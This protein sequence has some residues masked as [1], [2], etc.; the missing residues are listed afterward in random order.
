MPWERERVEEDP[1]RL[2]LVP[3]VCQVLR[4]HPGMS[5]NSA[6]VKAAA[7][8]ELCEQAMLRAIDRAHREPD[9]RD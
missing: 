1:Q 8:E 3:L 2:G 9:P 7:I 5:I 4:A 6:Y